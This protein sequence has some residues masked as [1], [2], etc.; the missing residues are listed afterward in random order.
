MGEI[1]VCEGKPAISAKL[2]SGLSHYGLAS[3][4]SLTEWGELG[5]VQ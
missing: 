5:L 3:L 4:F 2:L 1:V